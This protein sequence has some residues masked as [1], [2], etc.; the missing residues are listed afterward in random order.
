M[1][2]YIADSDVKEIINDLRLLIK[3]QNQGA[4]R[5][6][7]IELHPADIALLLGRLR[8][9]ERKYIFQILPDEHAS[10]VLTEL[11]APLSEQILEDLPEKKILT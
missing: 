4:L 10:A 8:K 3:R 11:E 1:L 2:R 9:N 6:I 7:L 5:N